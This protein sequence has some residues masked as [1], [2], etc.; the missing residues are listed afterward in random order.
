[1]GKRMVRYRLEA[2]NIFS[3]GYSGVGKSFGTKSG[4]KKE[5]RRLKKQGIYSKLKI[6]KT[7]I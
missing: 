2:K 4:V 1:M 5:M 3:S 6:K 7:Y